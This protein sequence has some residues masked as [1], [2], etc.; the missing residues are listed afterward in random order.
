M[1]R[2]IIRFAIAIIAIVSCLYGIRIAYRM[3]IARTFSEY[4]ESVNSLPAEYHIYDPT[5]LAEQAIN[6]SPSDPE[7]HF[8]RGVVLT[9]EGRNV[10]AVKEF[11]R[12]VALSPR[13]YRFWIRLGSMREGIGDETGALD[14]YNETVRLAPFYSQPRWQLGNLLLRMGRLQE[15]FA[16]L[17]NAAQSDQSLLP[18]LIDLA[19]G[20]SGGDT[21]VVEEFIQPQTTSWRLALARTFAKHGKAAESVSL[22]RAAGNDAS[23]DERRALIN[24]LLAAKQFNE[25]YE[26]WSVGRNTN[27]SGVV[28]ITDGGFEGQIHFDEPGFGWQLLRGSQSVRFSLD[29]GGPHVGS[30]S[31]RLDWSGDSNPATPVI[32][33][34][35]LVEPNTRYRL[36]FTARTHEVVTG[37]RALVVVTD[38]SGSDAHTVAQSAPLPDG[39]S[40]WQEYSI[41]FTTGEATRAVRINVE[42][43]SCGNALHTFAQHLHAS[44]SSS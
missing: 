21:R 42:R 37:G 25:A 12:A 16:E 43:Q 41:E 18:G 7:A 27:S 24:E 30:N 23:A 19:W 40:D 20:V 32:S 38:A 36:R 11:E 44:K 1:Y 3:G 17:R 15:A 9:D 39:S 14:A 34:L 29:K 22:F 6:L 31:L 35:V 2:A 33:Q 10:E 5:P 8:A 26:I 28:A 4:A 13:D